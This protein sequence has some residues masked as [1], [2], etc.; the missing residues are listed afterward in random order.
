MEQVRVAQA[1]PSTND[2][3]AAGQE[4]PDSS[5]GVICP[6]TGP[7]VQHPQVMHDHHQLKL[8]DCIRRSSVTLKSR[9]L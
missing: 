1:R 6:P 4:A 8:T 2:V 3:S 7:V 5:F 9:G